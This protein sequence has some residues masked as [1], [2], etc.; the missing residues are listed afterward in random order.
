VI[1]LGVALLLL[2]LITKIIS[3][4]DLEKILWLLLY[5]YRSDGFV[6]ITSPLLIII[7]VAY[8]LWAL[9]HHYST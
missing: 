2:P 4:I 7:G 5:V 6:F 8:F 1:L 3:T 9:I